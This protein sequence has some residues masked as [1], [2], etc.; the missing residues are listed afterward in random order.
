M[1]YN[2]EFM[3]TVHVFELPVLI[4]CGTRKGRSKI[5]E[6]CLYHTYAVTYLLSNIF[7]RI[8]PRYF[9][10]KFNIVK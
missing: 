10:V 7:I 6:H 3:Y 2:I 8:F 5:Y 9:R 1:I 4:F